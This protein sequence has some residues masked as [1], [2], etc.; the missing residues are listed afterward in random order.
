MLLTGIFAKNFYITSQ[1]IVVIPEINSFIRKFA[2]L[3][4]LL[5]AG[6]G[7]D[8]EALKKVKIACAR[9]SFLPSTFESLGIALLAFFLFKMDPIFGLLLG[10]LL[11]AVSPAVVVPEIIDVQAK[12][13]GVE[14]GIPTLV[15]AS[16]TINDV[17]AITLFTVTLSMV[18]FGHVDMQSILLTTVRAPLEEKS[19]EAKTM[20]II[21]E[22][23]AQPLLFALIGLQLSFGELAQ[24][25]VIYGTLILLFGLVV[26]V[27]AT[28]FSSYGS[29]FNAKEKC[30]IGI[31]WLP[32]ATVQAALAP[33]LLDLYN[34]DITSYSFKHEATILLSIGVLS[35]LLTAPF[36]AF[37]I[38]FTAPLLLKKP[39][40]QNQI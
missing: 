17:Y 16:C 40:G 5:R 2:F 10:F 11:S 34:S 4:I 22:Y 29:G 23:F 8:S 32:K 9:L 18:K 20:Q 33:A 6:L 7:L 24:K 1:C 30:F 37:L 28:Y 38:R 36:G 31:A 15:L 25:D 27:G 12:G 19:I 35:I 14:Q 13:L 3:V 26:R 39:V 21:W